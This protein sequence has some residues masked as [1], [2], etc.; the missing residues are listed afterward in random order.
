[1][2]HRVQNDTW[3]YLPERNS[4]FPT[5]SNPHVSIWLPCYGVIFS[6]AASPTQTFPTA[7]TIGQMVPYGARDR[8]PVCQLQFC[9]A[10]A[11]TSPR[12]RVDCHNFSKRCP[13][14][15]NDFDGRDLREG[16]HDNP[17]DANGTAHRK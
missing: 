2:R 9:D 8:L 16:R 15:A 1:T 10:A 17:I 14:V 6:S 3:K 7:V 4:N 13:D 11:V 12:D 5:R